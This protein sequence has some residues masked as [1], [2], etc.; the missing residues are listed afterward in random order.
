MISSVDHLG[1]EL[2]NPLDAFVPAPLFRE[3]HQRR[4]PQ[5]PAAAWD[6]LHSITGDSM[7]VVRLLMGLRALPLE[8]ARNLKGAPLLERVDHSDSSFVELPPGRDHEAVDFA[9]AMLATPP[10]LIR[11]VLAIRDRVVSRVGIA[12]ARRLVLTR[13][14]AA[15]RWPSGRTVSCLRRVRRRGHPRQ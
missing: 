3:T 12:S 6:A 1:D 2:T 5:P 11:V 8:M 7:P 15:R 13:R 10:I 9:A 4:I 14:G